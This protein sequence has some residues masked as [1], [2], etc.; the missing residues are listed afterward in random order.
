MQDTHRELAKQ[1]NT[2]ALSYIKRLQNSAKTPKEISDSDML[3]RRYTLLLQLDSCAALSRSAPFI[4]KF[5][6]EILDPNSESAFLQMNITDICKQKNIA[7]NGES[8][9]IL[10]LFNSAKGLYT[11]STANH[12]KQYRDDTIKMLELAAKHQRL[13]C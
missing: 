6:E 12:R 7:L 4:V 13:A 3:M 8:E 2:V 5:S 9:F 10:S 1:F 11:S